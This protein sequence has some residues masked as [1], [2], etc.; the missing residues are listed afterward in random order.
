MPPP[1]VDAAQVVQHRQQH[2]RAGQHTGQA[3]ARQAGLG[4]VDQCPHHRQPS[5]H[6]GEGGTIEDTAGI[7]IVEV[8]EADGPTVHGEGKTHDAAQAQGLDRAGAELLEGVLGDHGL[9]GLEASVN[10]AGRDLGGGVADVVLGEVSGH[11]EAPAVPVQQAHKAPRGTHHGHHAVEHPLGHR[12]DPLG[13]GHRHRA[14][15]EQAAASE[16]D[17]ARPRPSPASAPVPAPRWREEMEARLYGV[18]D[19]A[20]QTSD[21]VER[22]EARVRDLEAFA[23]ALSGRLLALHE[24]L[25]ALARALE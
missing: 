25:V 13:E 5:A 21:Q 2:R 22:V 10:D 3:S 1:R 6:S 19:F 15:H 14:L 17:I 23:E 11:Q 16:L 12:L 7:G 9:T 4:A 8:D 24:D 18:H 20:R